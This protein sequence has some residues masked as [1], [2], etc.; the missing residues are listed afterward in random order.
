MNLKKNKKGLVEILNNLKGKISPKACIMCFN[1]DIDILL[2]K[3]SWVIINFLNDVEDN[4][5]VRYENIISEYFKSLFRMYILNPVRNINIELKVE[6]HL[7]LKTCILSILGYILRFIF[8]KYGLLHLI[9]LEYTLM[10]MMGPYIT[11]NKVSIMYY[12]K[13]ILLGI[14]YTLFVITKTLSKE[15][16]IIY[17]MFVIF[18]MP[19]RKY[20][21]KYYK[22]I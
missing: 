1:A 16:L 12:I 20:M 22:N 17:Y 18:G 11:R 15:M 14:V 2:C 19:Y 13:V 8:I 7:Y 4:L 5:V 21:K 3:L 10:Y 6:R 9:F